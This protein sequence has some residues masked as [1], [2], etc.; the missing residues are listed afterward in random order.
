MTSYIIVHMAYSSARVSC[1]TVISGCYV[2]I[3]PSYVRS[4]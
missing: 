1:Y 4:D 3:N 2:K